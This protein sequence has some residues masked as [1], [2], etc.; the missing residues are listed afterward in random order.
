MCSR[1]AGDDDDGKEKTAKAESNRTTR[2]MQH[3]RVHRYLVILREVIRGMALMRSGSE[4]CVK[5]LKCR[6]SIKMK[7]NTQ[8][9]PLK[10]W[11]TAATIACALCDLFGEIFFG[12]EEKIRPQSV[13]SA[14]RNAE[15]AAEGCI[16]PCILYIKNST[17]PISC[18][19]TVGRDRGKN[20][21]KSVPMG[22]N[23]TRQLSASVFPLLT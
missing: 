18:T 1:P 2:N 10:N 22:W 8:G 9:W 7:I 17:Y 13:Q 3:E 12:P 23:S 11:R 20:A 16:S 5:V 14:R 19:S 15:R 4:R 21:G 6:D